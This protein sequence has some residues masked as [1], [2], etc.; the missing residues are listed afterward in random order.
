MSASY[1]PPKKPVAVNTPDLAKQASLV[2]VFA[3]GTKYNK[4]SK[5]HTEI[6][7]AIT[8]CLAKDMMPIHTVEKKGFKKLL[9]VLDKR[10]QI[11]SCN[12]FSQVAIP[13]LYEQCR[14]VVQA[15]FGVRKIEYF[16]ST[17]DLW[18][19]R[20]TEPYI[21]LTV[22]YITPEY[23]LVSKCLQTSYFPEDHK[24]QN[25]SVGLRDALDSWG[26]R[27]A[28]QVAI[29]TDNRSNIKKAAELKKWQRLQCFVRLLHNAV[30]NYYII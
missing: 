9:I 4:N 23:E 24:G 11:P 29:T 7:S 5:R 17:T 6:T 20:T 30:G 25:I 26:L 18:S 10:Y 19:S 13:Q 2:S 3:S 16:S 21:S 15:E 27:P 8:Y 22:H 12:Y 14:K 1:Y 28:H